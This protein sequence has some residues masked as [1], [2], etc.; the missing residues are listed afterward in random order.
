[1][2]N[3]GKPPTSKKPRKSRFG[4]VPAPMAGQG[5]LQ[6]PEHAPAAEGMTTQTKSAREPA[7]RTVQFNTKVTA[8]FDRDFRLVAVGQGLKHGALLEDMLAVYKKARKL[9]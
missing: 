6:A 5:V 8:D 4:D 9:D 2:A 1:M 7:K 3:L